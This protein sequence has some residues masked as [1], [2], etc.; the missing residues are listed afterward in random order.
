M[1]LPERELLR[2]IERAIDHL[3]N[4][5]QRRCLSHCF[6]PHAS[7]LL[8]EALVPENRIFLD[9]MSVETCQVRHGTLAV[10]TREPQRTLAQ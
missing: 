4:F 2:Q 7:G 9:E 1:F 8:A 10:C 6:R 5:D 3:E